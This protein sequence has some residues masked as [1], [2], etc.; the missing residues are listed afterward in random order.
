[1]VEEDGADVVQMA[2]ECEQASPRLSAPDLNLVIVTAGDEEG[3]CWV[4][5]NSSNG[6][7]VLFETINEGSHA[8]IPQLDRRRMEGDEDP[9]ARLRVSV[10]P[11]ATRGVDT[12]ETNRLGWKAIP[13]AREDFDS[14]C[15]KN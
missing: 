14:N 11:V 2:I 10:G 15:D 6:A 13:F 1:M 5:I 4:E 8:I 9:W 12:G 7:V 3:L